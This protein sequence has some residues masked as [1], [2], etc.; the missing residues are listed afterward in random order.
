MNLTY[1]NFFRAFEEEVPIPLK[2]FLTT[3]NYVPEK[4]VQV[5]TIQKPFSIKIKGLDEIGEKFFNQFARM[6]N[7][8]NLEYNKVAAIYDRLQNL[9]HKYKD[10]GQKYEI[11]NLS[12]YISIISHFIDNFVDTSN[13]PIR[14]KRS[15][16]K[17]YRESMKIILRFKDEIE[18]SKDKGESPF[19]HREV[20][21]RDIENLF[22]EGKL[23]PRFV[24]TLLEIVSEVVTLNRPELKDNPLE[25]SQILDNINEFTPEEME[26][27]FYSEVSKYFN[28][29]I[30]PTHRQRLRSQTNNL[31]GKNPLDQARG[32][33][34]KMTQKGTKISKPKLTDNV[35]RIDSDEQLGVHEIE[36]QD[37]DFNLSQIEKEE[38]VFPDVSIDSNALNNL[39][40]THEQDTIRPLVPQENIQSQNHGNI[41]ESLTSSQ[42]QQSTPIRDTS[43]VSPNLSPIEQG[44]TQGPPPTGNQV[45]SEF[46]VYSIIR[47]A[48][49][50]LSNILAQ[51]GSFIFSDNGHIEN[52]D[53][54]GKENKK[55]IILLNKEKEEEHN[56]INEDN[57]E[58]MQIDLDEGEIADSDTSLR[59]NKDIGDDLKENKDVGDDLKENKD[60]GDDQKE[61]KDLEDDQK[62]NKDLGDDQKDKLGMEQK[63]KNPNEQKVKK[64]VKPKIDISKSDP[65]H[66]LEQRLMINAINFDKIVLLLEET[67]ILD[68]DYDN[69]L[70]K[71]KDYVLNNKNIEVR[72]YFFKKLI[73]IGELILDFYA[74]LDRKTSVMHLLHARRLPNIG[75]KVEIYKQKEY[76]Y[77]YPLPSSIFHLFTAIP[78]CYESTCVE[79]KPKRIILTEMITFKDKQLQYCSS[80]KQVIDSNNK[81]IYLCTD[82][83]SLTNCQLNCNELH[84]C[85]YKH[86]TYYPVKLGYYQLQYTCNPL[87]SAIKTQCF[88]ERFN[89]VG[90][91]LERVI[92]VNLDKQAFAENFLK[93]NKKYLSHAITENSKNFLISN[94]LNILIIFSSLST[95]GL[96]GMAISKIIT[97]KKQ[98]DKKRKIWIRRTLAENSLQNEM[99]E[100]N[101]RQELK[102]IQIRKKLDS[103]PLN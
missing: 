21:I 25:L 35:P 97:S 50:N 17:I 30:L 44:P 89:S 3:A 75:N 84:N 55:D 85:D 27:E 45:N 82:L 70:D 60:V 41:E 37:S 57:T 4:S 102:H 93:L 51:A 5:L 99:L 47:M 28:M 38:E 32:V 7:T 61:N 79:A 23:Y 81:E 2:K 43:L 78:H 103:I 34:H 62:E 11:I 9:V 19:V 91:I 1:L 13:T 95:I 86:S 10:H 71:I 42:N 15:L 100:S 65:L 64:E 63:G 96:F 54:E 12:N 94:G 53:L 74:K 80:N 52:I 73:I 66:I 8:F 20:F 88:Y 68:S 58:P 39:D 76:L 46:S 49:E 24:D 29:E 83:K 90:S 18:K 26:N 56:K 92:N 101:R 72:Q 31:Q 67:S 69:K 16:P 77:Y 33:K 36:S 6:F 59:E 98:R 48:N 40:S 14:R 22:R 87:K